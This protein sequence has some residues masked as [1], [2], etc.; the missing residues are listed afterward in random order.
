MSA[1]ESTSQSMD[2]KLA[3][4]LSADVQGY[5]CLMGDDEEARR[6]LFTCLLGSMNNTPALSIR[7]RQGS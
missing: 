3:A 1:E 7:R 2:C 4:I 5:S 6:K